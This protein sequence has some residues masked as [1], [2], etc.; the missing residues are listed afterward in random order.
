MYANN[1]CM[2][3]IIVNNVQFL[4][5]KF[6]FCVI[7]VCKVKLMFSSRYGWNSKFL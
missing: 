6:K 2:F 3:V 5:L 7:R 1:M 4:N